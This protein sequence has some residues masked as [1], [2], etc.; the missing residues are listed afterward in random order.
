MPLQAGR[1]VNSGHVHKGASDIP[2][3][4]RADVG[5]VVLAEPPYAEGEG[6]STSLALPVGDLI[7]TIRPKVDRLVVVILSG[8]PVILDDV[9]RQA[10]A[11][12]AAWLPGTEGAG[13]ADVLLGDASF[14]GRTPY[15][16]PATPDDAPRT[17]KAACDGAIFPLGYG[18]DLT[19]SRWG[20]SPAPERPAIRW[21]RVR[22]SDRI[23]PQRRP[24][25]EEPNRMPLE[26][27]DKPWNDNVI[28]NF[29]E[30]AGKVTIPPYVGAN[31]L[32]MTTTGAKSGEAH[33]MPLGYTRDAERYVVVGSNSG[34]P[35]NADWVAN[36]RANPIVTLEVGS[37]TFQARAT[38][39]EGEE[40]H[41][42]F[43]AHATA[44]PHFRK[45]K[46]TTERELPVVTFERIA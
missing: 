36:V 42:L 8:R 10:D 21:R 7:K 26:A 20:P 11:V 38:V 31:L 6:D 24:R 12:V 39:T 30:N 15:A 22:R 16:W 3:S 46:E 5:I 23:D 25:R 41:R 1:D 32:L 14:T 35:M 44:I 29:R 4:A 17:G 40:R 43:E 19:G 13:V 27:G 37:D 33:T 2:A 18:L 9:L 45:Y 28:G 34:R